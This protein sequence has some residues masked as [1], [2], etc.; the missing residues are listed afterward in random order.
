MAKGPMK[1]C[2]SAEEAVIR[3]AATYEIVWLLLEGSMLIE[4]L[5]VVV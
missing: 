1:S 4:M 2:A 5:L 3:R